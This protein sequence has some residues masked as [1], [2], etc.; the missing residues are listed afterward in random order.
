MV[1]RRKKQSGFR[2]FVIYVILPLTAVDA[3]AFWKVHQCSESMVSGI[4]SLSEPLYQL[5]IILALNI[6]VIV[7]LL[8]YIAEYRR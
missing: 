5:A 7:F 6:T 3:Y 4:F 1:A 8:I 2:L